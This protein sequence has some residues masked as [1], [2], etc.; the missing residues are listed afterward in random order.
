MPSE[1]TKPGLF[2][3][4]PGI[5]I[6]S[7]G[8]LGASPDDVVCS[9]ENIVRLVEVKCSYRACH[10]TVWEMYSNDAFCYTRLKDKHEYYHVL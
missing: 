9:G 7:C 8:F 2:V 10:G 5:F 6:S 4:E 1:P 3:E